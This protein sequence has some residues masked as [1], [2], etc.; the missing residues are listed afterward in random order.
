MPI[1]HTSEAVSWTVDIEKRDLGGNIN[2]EI[3]PVKEF[4][5][6]KH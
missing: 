1:T 6:K 5:A 4:E 3:V 2:L